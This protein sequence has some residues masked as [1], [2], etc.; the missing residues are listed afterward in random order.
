MQPCHDQKAREELPASK[1][2]APKALRE[3]T[4]GH[5]ARGAR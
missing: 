3:S 4:D 2:T 1:S 5:L